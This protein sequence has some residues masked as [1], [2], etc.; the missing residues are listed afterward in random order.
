MIRSG[1]FAGCHAANLGF[2]GQ[3]FGALAGDDRGM[4]MSYATPQQVATRQIRD[5]GSIATTLNSIQT[6]C[7]AT[8][9]GPANSAPGSLPSQVRAGRIFVLSH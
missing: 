6:A 4:S 7:R 5:C 8:P 1:I 9:P 2:S 3:L